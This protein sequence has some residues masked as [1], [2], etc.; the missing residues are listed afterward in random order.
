MPAAGRLD[1]GSDGGHHL[2]VPATP[3]T[4]VRLLVR[5]MRSA[6]GRP[7]DARRTRWA[8]VADR[9]RDLALGLLVEEAVDGTVVTVDADTLHPAEVLA[10][11]VAVWAAGGAVRL[12]GS[13]PGP[14]LGRPTGRR[15]RDEVDLDVDRL[16]A[17]GRSADLAPD[18]HERRLAALDPA[19]P[20]VVGPAGVHS[21]TQ[22]AWAVRSVQQW[23][24]ELLPE[25]PSVVAVDGG[26]TDVA[27]VLLTRWWPAL[28][29]ARTVPVRPGTSAAVIS[30][31]GPDVVVAGPSEWH[32]VAA[33]VR[34][35]APAMRLGPAMLRAG[36]TV[37]A[38]EPGQSAATTWATTTWATTSRRVVGRRVRDAALVGSVAAGVCL[39]GLRT[40]DGRD[41][42][43]AGIPVVSTWLEPGLAA[44]VAAGVT[45]SG[46]TEG[47]GRPL[48]GRTVDVGRPTTVTGGDVD[49]PVPVTPTRA[50]RHRVRLPAGDR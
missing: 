37:A 2:T 28:E 47:W 31:I 1:S 32:H 29:G 27:G 24:R 41:L 39:G 17:T 30:E 33:R 50:D 8:D 10:C 16:V 13:A 4:L 46:R 3:P 19:A 9:A 26:R 43:A 21:H 40:V 25:G 36:R 18:A 35:V 23:L 7:A 34:E 14:V 42:D 15:D 49:G 44:P 6:A 48:P 20:A 38:G 11:E 45:G 22:M 5:G 12:A